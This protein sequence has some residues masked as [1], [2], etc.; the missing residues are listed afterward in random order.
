[1]S[2][3]DESCTLLEKLNKF[4]VSASNRNSFLHTTILQGISPSEKMIKNWLLTGNSLLNN[5]DFINGLKVWDQF[6]KGIGEIL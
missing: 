2:L 1:M 4:D 3:A 5:E 6:V